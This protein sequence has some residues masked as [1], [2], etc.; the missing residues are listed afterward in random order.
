MQRD[1]Y[2]AQCDG[3]ADAA[4]FVCVTTLKNKSTQT[5][6]AVAV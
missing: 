3:M 1:E 4:V 6:V 5:T 2:A